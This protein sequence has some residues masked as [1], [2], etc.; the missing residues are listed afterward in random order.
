MLVPMRRGARIGSTIVAWSAV[1]GIAIAA[2]AACGDGT[3][4]ALGS[5]DASTDAATAPS[6]D[7]ASS[8]DVDAES[9]DV[10]ASDADAD[11]VPEAPPTC[12]Q[13]FPDELDILRATTILGICE[14]AD[15]TY[16]TSTSLRG[17]QGGYEYPSDI[18]ACVLALPKDWKCTDV[19]ACLGLNLALPLIDGG[20]E[21]GS[22]MGDLAV[23]CFDGVTYTLDCAKI[24]AAC[25]PDKSG[26]PGKERAQC[27]RA[28]DPS[29]VDAGNTGSCDLSGRA[30][31]CGNGYYA[32]NR[33]PRCSDFGFVCNEGMCRLPDGGGINPLYGFDDRPIRAVG[34][35]CS[36]SFLHR[37]SWEGNPVT[38]DCRCF[39][40][41]FSCYPYP[42]IS[43]MTFCGAGTDCVPHQSPGSG[44]CGDGGTGSLTVC[45]AGKN[46]TFT[47]ASIGL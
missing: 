32:S 1:F 47:C 43:N 40:P 38:V 34:S 6:I 19:D 27:T 2:G 33:G 5:G 16:E 20:Y 7:S 41:S 28:G 37:T 9:T 31:T 39:G 17:I 3:D 44:S 29:C 36:G 25:V 14:R 12:P 46:F 13:V 15:S 42:G 10:G 11:A 45:S 8:S 23:R 35:S 18:V 30:R 24:G 26:G 21:C 4:E 22:C